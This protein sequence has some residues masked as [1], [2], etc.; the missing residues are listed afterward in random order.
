MNALNA[1]LLRPQ[2]PISYENE[3][4]ARVAIK[5]LSATHLLRKSMDILQTKE[6]QN[7]KI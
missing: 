1:T 4:A 2:R 5:E 6:N 3:P 7:E